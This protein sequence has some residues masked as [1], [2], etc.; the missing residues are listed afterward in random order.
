MTKLKVIYR[1]RV[2]L[3]TLWRDTFN[4]PLSGENAQ[5]FSPW[6]EDFSQAKNSRNKAC[7]RVAFRF[8]LPA[9]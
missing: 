1:S 2:F 4:F 8:K 3:K 9:L 7:L 6:Q 5:V